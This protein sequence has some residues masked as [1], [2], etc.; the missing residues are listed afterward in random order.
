[1]VPAKAREEL[2]SLAKSS[3]LPLLFLLPALLI[4]FMELSEVDFLP[5]CG[6]VFSIFR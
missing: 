1:M 5:M 4:P 2:Y 6:E 3:G